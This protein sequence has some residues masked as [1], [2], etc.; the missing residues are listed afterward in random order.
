V[1]L[2][3]PMQYAASMAQNTACIAFLGKALASLCLLFVGA[4]LDGIENCMRGVVLD[5]TPGGR[6][7]ALVGVRGQAWKARAA[8][9]EH[10]YG[11]V[12]I[13]FVPS[14][15]NYP[16]VPKFLEGLHDRTGTHVGT[17]L[18][19][20]AFRESVLVPAPSMPVPPVAEPTAPDAPGRM[21]VCP[22]CRACYD[23]DVS[24]CPVDSAATAAAFPIDRTIEGRHRLERLLGRG[25]M[26]A[27]F[28]ATDQRLHRPVAIKAMLSDVFR[29]ANALQ[30]FE[31]EAKSAAKLNHP[32]IISIYDY[33][34]IG[35]RE[36]YMVMELL[37]GVTWRSELERLKRVPP[38]IACHW[39]DQLIEGVR[40]ADSAG[41]LHRNL[42]PE[43]V[44]LAPTSK[45]GFR[46]KISRFW[47]GKGD[48]TVD[49][50]RTRA[51]HYGRLGGRN[52]RLHATGAIGRREG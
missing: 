12:V 45:G 16:E 21:Q 7:Y 46:V 49:E 26:G 42:K 44:F 52:L 25:G 39:A 9:L 48:D 5:Q 40:E 22:E 51:A 50:R 8:A 37:D 4:S 35:S 3:G 31:R 23:A 43:N 18:D 1:L 14:D 47:A 6:H 11:I 38:P 27:V 28:E 30:R 29:H 20:T 33:G 41:I 36:A 17:R 24:R 15:T 34:V 32:N 19:R 13:P 2:F 10:R